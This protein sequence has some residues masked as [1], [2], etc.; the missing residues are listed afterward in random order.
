MPKEST[1]SERYDFDGAPL[2]RIEVAH[3]SSAS[4]FST[5]QVAAQANERLTS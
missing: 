5:A 3:C 2:S 4:N 1:G